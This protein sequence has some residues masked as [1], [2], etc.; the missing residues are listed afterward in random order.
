MEVRPTSGKGY[1]LRI[2]VTLLCIYTREIK[3]REA[4]DIVG[5]R[6]FSRRPE[7]VCNDGWESSSV[8]SDRLCPAQVTSLVSSPSRSMAREGEPNHMAI[9]RCQ[10][11][12]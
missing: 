10:S 7:K 2:L 4:V 8:E 12:F 3:L 1:L 9:I 11:T 5:D 6:S